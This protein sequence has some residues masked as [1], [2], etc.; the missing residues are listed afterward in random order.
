[1]YQKTAFTAFFILITITAALSQEA[2][3]PTYFNG[4]VK[5]I[6]GATMVIQSKDGP[7]E[8]TLTSATTFK[9]VPPETPRITA[10]VDAARS[11]IGVGDKIIVS[12]IVP[13]DKKSI[14]ARTV[15]LMTK[16]DIAKKMETDREAWK[17]RG[18]AGRVTAINPA[19]KEIT[20]AMRGIGG[21]TPIKVVPKEKAEFRRYAQDSVKFD[22]AKVSGFNEL[23]VGDQLRALGDKSGDGATFAAEE[24]VSGAFR[25]VGGVI[26]AMDAEKKEITIK[27]ILTNKPVVIAVN[28]ASLLKKFPPE[29]AQ[30]MA[31][32]MG[33]G[34]GGGRIRPQGG[35]V[36]DGQPGGQGAGMR[37]G[38]G[39][40]DDMLERF[41]SISLADLKVGDS[42]AASSSA[43][44]G[45]NRVRAI[46]LLSGIEAFL[47]V[48]QASRGGGGGGQGAPSLNIP[49]LDNI[50]FP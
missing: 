37:A 50:G 15:Y 14:P 46:K 32:R 19:T 3:K 49:G 17:T 11:D 10:A 2:Q 23:A 42:I 35:G 31:A 33:G 8:I 22:A 16:S 25:M 28:D 24:I 5:S 45:A 40:F 30:M 4:E 36:P 43:S 6:S 21:E 47:K 7:V 18:I 39:E 9:R 38:R 26:T 12:S 1:M 20:V 34:Q 13:T 41:P 27:D 29:M 48:S 44:A